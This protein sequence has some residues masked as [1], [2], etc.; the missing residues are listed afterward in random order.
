MR[1]RRDAAG[2]SD[3]RHDLGGRGALARDVGRPA[4]ADQ[5]VERL[6][7]TGDMAGRDQGRGDHRPR[8]GLAVRRRRHQRVDVDRAAQLAEP[9][10]DFMRAPHAVRALA[11]EKL[12]EHHRARIDEVPEHVH[13]PC[14]ENRR[15]L[16]AG[17]H[18]HAG[19][20]ACSGRGG[21]PRGRV[22]IGHAEHADA[23]RHGALDER[24][25]GELAVGSRGM[26]VEIDH[27]R[28]PGRRRARR[29]GGAFGLAAGR[30]RPRA[31]SARHSR[32]SSSRCW[33]S[34]SANSRNTCLPSESSN[35]S[36]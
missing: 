1:E 22:V 3:D 34:S 6:A 32:I 23:G 30:F 15:H 17:H 29:A 19:R 10:A 5:A 16:D 25:R 2:A 27:A 21:N 26:G 13:V 36:P 20:G 11:R 31:S 35:R 18:G 12:G 4:L 8:Q 7:R 33:R 14:V 9:V 28:G 24:R